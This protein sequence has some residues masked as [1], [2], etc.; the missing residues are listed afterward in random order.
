MS[1]L[2]RVQDSIV[3]AIAEGLRLRL[4]GEEKAR[5]GGFGT[6]S[7]DAYELFLKGRF[8]LQR[9]TEEDDLEA[10]KLFKQATEIDPN[11]LDAHLAVVS[12]YARSAGAYASPREAAAHAEETLAK[13]AAID[14]NNVAVRVASA[15]LRFTA[16]HDWAATE[17][18]YRAVM[19]DPA[20]FRTMQ[21]HPISV[22]FVAIGRPDEAVALLER[23]LVVDPG[24]LESRVMLGSF[25]LQNGRLDDALRVYADLGA[26]A[27]EDPRP[28]FGAADVYK[29]RGDFARAAE[30]RRNAYALAGDD[31]AARAF[32]NATTEAAYG[33]A[34]I[35]VARARLRQLEELATRRYIPAFDIARLRAQVG[36]RE[37]ALAGLELAATEGGYVGL[38]LL[39]VDE[40]WDAV[41][42][43]P[44]F[45]ALVRRLGIP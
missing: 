11:F 1:D 33:Q 43:D 26:E 28:L 21:Y 20:L 10:L 36:D 4:S 8:M 24:N 35:T 18:E 32:T 44:R 25:L 2:M 16:T 17:R 38:A 14:P 45:A 41:R 12:T 13:A 34:E 42:T 37:G 6:N 23:A 5:L 9:D 31:D 19:H 39:K 3:L 22:F 27:P 7:P 40:A 29:R 15:H 30:S